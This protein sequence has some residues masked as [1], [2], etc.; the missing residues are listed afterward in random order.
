MSE[1]KHYRPIRSFV[2]RTGRITD[3]QKSALEN[4]WP[5][6]GLE[7]N[8]HLFD[9]DQI[10]QR[11][12]PLT[13]EIGFGMG[14]ALIAMAQNNAQNNYL[15]I[16]VH[17]PG[18]GNI[19]SQIELHQLNNIRL[20]SY[21]AVEVLKHQISDASVDNFCI[22]F[23][24]PWHKTKHHK[25]RLINESFVELLAKKTKKGGKIFLATDWENYAHQMLEVFS[26][27][28]NFKNLSSTND[29]VNRISFR[30]LTKFEKRGHRLGHEV[31]DLTFEHI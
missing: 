15:G 28:S 17:T 26:D 1:Q 13:I 4:L 9:F 29:F 12:A 5:L 14:E 2:R 24:D 23:S 31:W 20:I 19:L 3:R 8:N 6:Y 10:F 25:R 18:I 22:F 7:F 30:P 27:N 16:E 11:N 21:D